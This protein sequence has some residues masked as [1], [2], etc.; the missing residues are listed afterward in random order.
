MNPIICQMCGSPMPPSERAICE[1]CDQMIF[2]TSVS[3]TATLASSFNQGLEN[4]IRSN[5]YPSTARASRPVGR[6]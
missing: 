3:H 2:S 5:F 1:E 6:G 4:P